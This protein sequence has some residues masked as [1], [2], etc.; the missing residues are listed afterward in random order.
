MSEPNIEAKLTF[1]WEDLYVLKA[2]LGLGLTKLHTLFFK[3]V[4][5]RLDEK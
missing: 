5:M 3:Y 1:K 4:D 2:G